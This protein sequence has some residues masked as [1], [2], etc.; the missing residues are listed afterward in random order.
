MY[1]IGGETDLTEYELDH[2]EGFMNSKPVR[3]G[4]SNFS[5]LQTDVLG[6]I[7]DAI[8]AFF[9][10]HNYVKTMTEEQFSFV[11]SLVNQALRM[12]DKKDH[13]IWEFRKITEHFLFSKLLSV[14]AGT[15]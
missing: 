3:I 5:Q 12:W 4:N 1:G 15:G 8:Y 13:G 10:E 9:I 7:L 11:E 6:E 14:E 2:F